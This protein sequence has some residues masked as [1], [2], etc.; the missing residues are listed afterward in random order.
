LENIEIC[1]YDDPKRPVLQCTKTIYSY[2]FEIHSYKSEREMENE[3]DK[4]SSSNNCYYFHRQCTT[5]C[6]IFELNLPARQSI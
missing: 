4:N 6:T 3:I 1:Y 2:P 5:A